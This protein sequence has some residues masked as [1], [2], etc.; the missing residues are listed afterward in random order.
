MIN[1]VKKGFMS[2]IDNKCKNDPEYAYSMSAENYISTSLNVSFLLRIF[3]LSIVI[4]NISYFVGMFWLVMCQCVEDFLHG[5]YYHELS[6]SVLAP[7]SEDYFI[8]ANG[9]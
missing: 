4:I 8:P 1:Q 6:D 5:L 9:M 2:H 7:Y 3:F